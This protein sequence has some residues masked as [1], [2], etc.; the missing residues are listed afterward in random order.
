MTADAH[1][2]PLE[3]QD[4]SGEPRRLPPGTR[5]EVRRRFDAAWASGFE[6]L[7]ADGDGYRLRR[8]SDGTEIPVPFDAADVRRAR[9]RNMWWI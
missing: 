7:R 3:E 4:E 6:V 1:D 5:V 9:R 2:A 8:L